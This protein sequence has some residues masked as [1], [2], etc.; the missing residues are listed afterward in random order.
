[1]VMEGETDWVVVDGSG[2]SDR[3][4]ESIGV[5]GIIPHTYCMGWGYGEE[6]R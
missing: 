5:V 2:G 4:F 1:M 6:G 3:D